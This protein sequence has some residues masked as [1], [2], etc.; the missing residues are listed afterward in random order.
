MFSF[1]FLAAVYSC[2]SSDRA[3]SERSSSPSLFKLSVSFPR[4]RPKFDETKAKASISFF[5]RSP[6]YTVRSPP[7]SVCG[8]SCRG[9]P[10][11]RWDR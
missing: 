9:S 4:I 3:P 11:H 5:L 1:I 8:T 7:V 10:Y 2:R 6:F